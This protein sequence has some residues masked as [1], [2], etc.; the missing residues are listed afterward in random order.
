MVRV[1]CI[2]AFSLYVS[3][4]FIVIKTLVTFLYESELD[5]QTKDD[6]LAGEFEKKNQKKN[7]TVVKF[8]N[9]AT[10]FTKESYHNSL[11]K[12]YNASSQASV[13]NYKYKTSFPSSS[14]DNLMFLSLWQYWWWFSFC[15]LTIMYY[16]LFVRV[17]FFRVLKINPKLNTSL[18]A[19]GK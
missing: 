13:E 8:F 7:T 9:L 3:I 5:S 2:V 12:M 19:H 4:N 6:D 11:F 10:N 18:K 16:I 1:L 15:F 17:F 14:A